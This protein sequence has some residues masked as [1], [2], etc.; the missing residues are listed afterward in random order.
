[1]KIDRTYPN[2]FYIGLVLIWGLFTIGFSIILSCMVFNIHLPFSKGTTPFEESVL[3][4]D[5]GSILF[6]FLNFLLYYLIFRA[7]YYL[8]NGWCSASI[9]QTHLTV[10]SP[11]KAQM[12]SF[13]WNDLK[14]YSTS[15]DIVKGRYGILW[16]CDSIVVYT[17]NNEVFEF[18]K[19]FNFRF[20]IIEKHLKA[21]GVK[22]LGFEKFRKKDTLFVLNFRR[23]YKFLR[24][25]EPI[26][27]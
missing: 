4:L 27:E 10:I 2:P 25:N 19:L 14:G 12:K 15:Q 20:K 1:M 23:Q 7:F 18:I 6:V 17:K 21:N 16:Y 11:L 3:S 22:D 24:D 8:V 26:E 5:V 13:E 9:S